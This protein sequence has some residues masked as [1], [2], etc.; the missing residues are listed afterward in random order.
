MQDTIGA[1]VSIRIIKIRVRVLVRV[2]VKFTARVKTTQNPTLN[3]HPGLTHQ[4]R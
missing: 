3:L 1:M 4:I 2:G